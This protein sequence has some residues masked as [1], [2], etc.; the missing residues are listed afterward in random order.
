MPGR[1]LPWPGAGK[2]AASP[3]K[4]RPLQSPPLLLGWARAWQASVCHQ[5]AVSYPW[6]L[7]S[8]IPSHAVCSPRRKLGKW[9]PG[10]LIRLGCIVTTLLALTPLTRCGIWEGEGVTTS[11]SRPVHLTCTPRLLS[12]P[13]DWSVHT[14]RFRAFCV[15]RGGGCFNPRQV[16]QL[17][18]HRGTFLLSCRQ[19]GVAF[20]QAGGTKAAQN[21]FILT[22][23]K[24]AES[25]PV[26]S[27]RSHWKPL[28]RTVA[29]LSTPEDLPWSFRGTT[30]SSTHNIH[31][32]ALLLPD[33]W[34]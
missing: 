9:I 12:L 13:G 31:F 18:S 15:G 16:S 33:P 21:N 1:L 24:T 2:A 34:F 3:R 32:S 22:A 20:D 29:L 19:I 5:E 27:P 28:E 8:L 26:L 23:G 14:L 4:A 11:I 7:F 17:A 30:E 25:K 6:G 10:C